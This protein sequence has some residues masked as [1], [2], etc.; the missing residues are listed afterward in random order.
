[1]V[2]AKKHHEL[3]GELGS[4]V[5]SKYVSD[6][7]AVLLSYTRDMSPIPPVKPQG[8]VVRPGS[9]EE[10]IELV[11]LANQTRTPLIPMGGKASVGGCPPGQPG[12][13][14]LVDM[15]RMDKVLEIDEVNMT[16]TAQ[17]GIM[18][19][20]LV[21]KVNERGWDVHTAA[22][23][24]Y[25]VTAGGQLSGMPGAGYGTYTPSIGF[26]WHNLLGIK[27][28]LPNGSIIDTGTGKGSIS[29][30]RGHTW[31]RGMHGPDLT[32]M[33]LGD[34][35]IFGIKVE[36]TYRMF[37]L[38]KFTKSGCRCWD[39]LDEAYQAYLE[40]GEIDP[41]LYM[42]P[43]AIAQIYSPE[44]MSIAAPGAEPTWFFFWQCIGN[45][46]EEVE[47]KAKTTDAI[48]VKHGGRVA[49]PALAAYAE[50]FMVSDMRELGKLGAMG[51]QPF[52]DLIAPRRDLVECYRWS[53][54]Y[55][56][57]SLRERG[58]DPTKLTILATISPTGT[59]YGITT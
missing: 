47:L 20:E 11:R 26:N 35:G 8:V 33:F 43:Y 32:G 21:S 56:S 36:A 30:Y 5:G 2:V 23:P 3:Y 10:V 58:F 19:G 28:V 44:M 52:F 48:L 59:G 50:N 54:E 57:N 31:A 38:P 53:Q 7:Y 17:C 6:D 15:R 37:R 39:T 49:E 34:G 12:R 4:I 24:H 18:M 25:V 51:E 14:I 41:F 45:S 27:V 16:V 9:V 42:Q 22:Q 46:E 40:L 29:T 1:M 13:G 55:I